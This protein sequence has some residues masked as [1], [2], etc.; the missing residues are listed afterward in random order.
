[1]TTDRVLILGATSAIGMAVAEAHARRGNRLYLV[2]RDRAKLAGRAEHLTLRG[3]ADAREAIADLGRPQD[4]AAMLDAAWTAYGG[5]DRVIVAYGTLP[6]EA[7]TS[8]DWRAAADALQVNLVSVVTLLDRVIER[9]TDGT[10]RIAVIGSVAGDRG[11]ARVALY[12]A[13]KGGLERYVEALQQRERHGRCSLTLIKPGWVRTPMTAH[14]S[15]PRVAV[16]AERAASGIVS[17]LD[18]NAPVAYVPGWWRLAMT[19]V[20]TIPRALFRRLRF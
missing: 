12:S 20:R 9:V 4:Q 19:V 1:M 16:S 8:A 15:L 10:C 3:A 14:L 5:F 7:A 11:R 13:A 6:D 18:R 17:A 2:A